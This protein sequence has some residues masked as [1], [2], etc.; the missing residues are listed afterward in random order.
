LS[1][2]ASSEVGKFLC[3]DAVFIEEVALTH[4]ACRFEAIDN[5]RSIGPFRKSCGAAQAHDL[6]DSDAVKHNR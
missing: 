3:V 5:A 6:T 4:S 1:V 2:N